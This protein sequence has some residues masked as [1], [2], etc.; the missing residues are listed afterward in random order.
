MAD[1]SRDDQK[2]WLILF[3]ITAIRARLNSLA[4]QRGLF[5]LLALIIGAAAGLV[6]AALYF[7]PLEF[8]ASGIILA[9]IALAGGV[10]AIRSAW[11]V[12]AS[13]M[14]AA[15]IADTRA[16]LKGRLAT[17]HAMAP[18][19]PNSSLWP[20]LLEDTYGAR[21]SFEPSRIEPRWLSRSAYA[22]LA[23][24]AIAAVL[25]PQAINR[26]LGSGVITAQGGSPGT[27]TA[28]IN[29]LDIRPADP[30]LAPNAE[31]YADAATLQKL[32]DRMAQEQ[33][34]GSGPL[35]KLMDRARSFADA[36]QGEI[37][38]RPAGSQPPV[39]MRLTD[40]SGANGSSNAGHPKP[41]SAQ[42]NMN[43]GGTGSGNNQTASNQLPPAE[44][45]PPL[46]DGLAA[47][48]PD[49]PQ[50]TNPADNQTGG[51]VASPISRRQRAGFRSRIGQRSV[52]PV[53]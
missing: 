30:A 2:L 29:S 16:E 36:V 46:D 48:K 18:A 9:L 38:G 39:R 37:N 13:P 19:P 35:S 23:A 45:S 44:A 52:E 17:V 43:S 40:N 25:L 32:Q 3:Q 21:N 53:R 8:L 10:I 49:S 20:Y 15:A 28:D 41:R 12:R 42:P 6:G 22:L 1:A 11:R 24:L 27:V 34:A 26:R 7:G 14:R 51:T 50:G 47:A 5:W 4:L 31:I 33:A